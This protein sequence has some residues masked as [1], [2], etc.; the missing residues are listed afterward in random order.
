MPRRTVPRRWDP[1]FWRRAANTPVHVPVRAFPADVQVMVE[2]LAEEVE[3]DV[4]TLTIR[5]QPAGPLIRDAQQMPLDLDRYPGVAA[6]DLHE[7]GLISTQL[8]NTYDTPAGFA[9][10]KQRLAALR[11]PDVYRYGLQQYLDRLADAIKRG[12]PVPPIM[13]VNRALADGRHRALAAHQLGRTWLPVAEIS[14]S[15]V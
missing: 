7:R 14:A 3:C 9:Q 5:R 10:L 12:D 13:T 8:L 11:L 6:F 4:T 15:C 2:Q 1:A